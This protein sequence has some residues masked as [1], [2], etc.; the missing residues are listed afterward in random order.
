[1]IQTLQLIVFLYIFTFVFQ[2][3][4]AFTCNINK[5]R[6]KFVPSSWSNINYQRI[7]SF[8]LSE[9]PN[10]IETT[11]TIPKEEEE[12][13]EYIDEDAPADVVGA[14]FF[15]GNAEKEEYFDPVAEEKA[16]A[17]FDENGSTFIFERFNN[18]MF[19]NDVISDVAK[20]MQL[21]FNSI[22]FDDDENEGGEEKIIYNAG[23]KWNSPLKSSSANPLE[24][25]KKAKE[26]YK[27]VHVSILSGKELSSTTSSRDI[28]LRWEISI[29]WPA[30]YE[31]CVVITGTSKVT[32][33]QEPSSNEY[34]I[35]SQTDTPDSKEYLSSIA[36]QLSPRFWDLYHVGMTP[37]A[38]L[39]PKI[40]LSDSNIFT[41]Y[42]VYEIP[43]TFVLTPT[44]KDTNDRNDRLGQGVPNHA[45]ST[46]IKTMGPKKQRYVPTSPVEVQIDSAEQC[47]KWS[48]FVPTEISSHPIQQC[49]VPQDINTE[50]CQYTYKPKR[51]VA[52]LP[53]GGS[54]QDEDVSPVRKKLYESI[55]Q[56]NE[57]KPKLSNGKPIFFYWMN[58]CK[59]CFVKDGLGMAVYD[60]RPDFFKSNEIGIELERK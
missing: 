59:A 2:E 35:I 29:I 33:K 60:Y 28:E 27:R 26:F 45:F 11:S 48:I 1:M 32:I 24:E 54:P 18:D 3:T 22:C 46:A 34:K 41:P 44:I 19:E 7:T 12:A 36:S 9:K 8:Q 10:D 25:I 47:L 57:Y 51:I 37:S 42:K 13:V 5:K 30:A 14:K 16:S 55:I 17:K 40:I 20:R 31:P 23:F 53:Y 38:Q 43:P 50:T 39:L 4:N 58:H 21:S 49:A 56:N 6:T 52:T 15:G